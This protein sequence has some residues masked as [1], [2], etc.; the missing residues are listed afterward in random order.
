MENTDLCSVSP[1]LQTTCR[2]P[3]ADPG[4]GWAWIRCFSN[5]TST[6]S[7]PGL[8]DHWPPCKPPSTHLLLESPSLM[9]A[10]INVD[11]AFFYVV[12]EIGQHCCA[13][14]D[15]TAAANNNAHIPCSRAFRILQLRQFNQ[16][17]TSWTLAVGNG[18]T[19]SNEG[20]PSPI[21]TGAVLGRIGV[22]GNV[23]TP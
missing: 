19:L 10:D 2:P 13:L 16:C 3:Q 9:S 22:V 12:R 4:G 20:G 21:H 23:A 18:G 5:P 11:R 14:C 6:H 1:T 8:P 7:A 17:S 15:Q